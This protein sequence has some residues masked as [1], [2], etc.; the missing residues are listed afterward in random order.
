MSTSDSIVK[1]WMELETKTIFDTVTDCIN[2]VETT[3][4]T[5]ETLKFS[6]II[7]IKKQ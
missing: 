5:N 2:H 3:K 4:A 6:E 7:V 1:K